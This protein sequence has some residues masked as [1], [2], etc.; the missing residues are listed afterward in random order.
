VGEKGVSSTVV[1]IIVIVVA[2]VGVGGYLLL[3]GEERTKAELPTRHVG[4]E[5][6]YQVTDDNVYTFHYEVIAEETVDNKDCY[7]FKLSSTPPY[8]GHLGGILSGE[9][10][11]VEKET[12]LTVKA[13]ISGEYMGT[14][15]TKT[16]TYIHHSGTDRW[17]IE[18]GKEVNVTTTA[19]EN[20]SLS[21]SRSSTGTVTV[22]V[23]KREDITVPAGTFKCFKV[24]FYDEYDS[25]TS[26]SWYSDSVK[27]WVKTIYNETGET[28]E[29]ISYSIQ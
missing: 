19:I 7:V 11:W 1:I 24:V 17:P 13:Q 12:G 8:R 4:N 28:K 20:S 5:W 3:K 6:M 10:M 22:K 26:T 27:Y 14:P 21:G 25:I 29:L 15:F 9:N 18:V 23:E 2:V 16:T